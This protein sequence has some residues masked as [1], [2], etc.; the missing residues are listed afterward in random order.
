MLLQI[1]KRKYLPGGRQILP[2][3][4]VVVGSKKCD[5]ND[6]A[7]TA[8]ASRRDGRDDTQRRDGVEEF[9]R[10][11]ARLAGRVIIIATVDC[12]VSRSAEFSESVTRRYRI[13]SPRRVIG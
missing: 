4:T 8:T 1:L 9:A 6:P 7:P 10:R 3:S 11:A 12:L 5:D 2:S 13:S